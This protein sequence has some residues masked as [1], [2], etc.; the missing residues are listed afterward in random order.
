MHHV[1]IM[2]KDWGLTEK[3]L[4][5]KKSIESR[6]YKNKSRPWDSIS[7]GDTVFFKNSGEPVTL[8]ATVRKVV[9]YANLTSNKV[10]EL[11]NR[12]AKRDGID[13]KDVQKF[14]RLF[15][16]KKYCLLIFLQ[17]P[18]SV[19]PFNITKKGFGAMAAWITV[20]N[21]KQIVLD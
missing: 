9:Q 7:F 19:R 15:R 12:Y 17:D 3:I 5:G 14:Y 1:A 13:Q 8:K 20:D 11:L 10:K 18:V 4:S 2:R 16:D 6:W 21:I